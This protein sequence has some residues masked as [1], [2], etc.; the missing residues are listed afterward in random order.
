MRTTT[1]LVTD[2]VLD[3]YLAFALNLDSLRFA[4]KAELHAHDMSP[5]DTEVD[6]IIGERLGVAVDVI[7]QLQASTGV[8]IQLDW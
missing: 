2:P 3:T 5:T 8:E 4:V 1:Q 6:S 7:E